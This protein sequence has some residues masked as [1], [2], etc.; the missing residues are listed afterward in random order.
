MAITDS[1]N[2]RNAER[3]QAVKD[4]QAQVTAAGPTPVRE[5]D[6]ND[7]ITLVDA[8]TGAH[9]TVR[10]ADVVALSA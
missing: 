1:D 7:Y 6:D 5:F 4:W 9:H 3:E 2:L 8:E 10:V